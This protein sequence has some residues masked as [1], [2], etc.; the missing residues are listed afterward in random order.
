MRRGY[1][2]S[3][4]LSL[5]S[6][7]CSVAHSAEPAAERAAITVED[8]TANAFAA[9]LPGLTDDERTQFFVGNSYFNQAWLGA[10]SSVASRDG[11]GPLFNARSCSACHFRDGRGRPPDE[12]EPLRS[13]LVRIS[14]PARGAD[15]APQPDPVYGDQLQTESVAG[16]PREVEARV[17]YREAQ[18]RY[19]DGEPYSLRTPELSLGA[20][21]YG[22]LA[23]GLQTSLRVAPAMIGLGL[24][25][26]VS[27]Q[28]VLSR[29]D[30]HDRDH[31]GIS[32]RAQ[33]VS[34][35][36]R[37]AVALGRFG[38]KAEQPSVRDQTAAAFLGD[39]GL[40]SRAL[41]HENHT[42]R[43]AGAV[44]AASGG[45]P[46]VDEAILHSVVLYARTLAVPS[47][48]GR[49]RAAVRRGEQLFEG[50]RCVRCHVS[51]LHTQGNAVP[52]EL[53]D[54]VIHPY[55]DLLLHDL[56]EGL[57][58]GRP[59]FQAAGAEWRTA[60][61]WG[62]GLVSRVNGHTFYLHDGR[63]RSLP[64]AV[65]WHGGEAAAAR[66]EFVRM[67]APQR[68]DLVSFLESL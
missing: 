19:A 29:V 21:G 39:M 46:E 37:G 65:L 27:A 9:P 35:A 40:T 45:A 56:G 18:G 44:S 13:L 41:E 64:E 22:P 49:E 12:G 5:A 11:L 4:L 38:W 43:Q 53:A 6:A 52:R 67:S 58:D 36:T 8:E 25:E 2:A 66:D 54:R 34:T 60:P 7:S 3:V 17:R 10:P 31:D 16:S 63:A 47:Q 57:S 50:A 30:E 61:L 32:G 59:S 28:A 24:L 48:R 62:L 14:I 26:A 23:E 1:G 55:T 15:G 68:A 20:T 51:T 33:Y 42:A